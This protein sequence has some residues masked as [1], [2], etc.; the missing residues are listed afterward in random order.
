MHD[1]DAELASSVLHGQIKKHVANDNGGWFLVW[2]GNGRF[3]ADA[4]KFATLPEVGSLVSFLPDFRD[5][6]LPKSRLRRIHQI[7][8]APETEEETFRS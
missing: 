7:V 3:R 8:F 6:E 1:T 2:S 5:S 4:C